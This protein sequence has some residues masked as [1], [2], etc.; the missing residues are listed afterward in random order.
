MFF[1]VFEKNIRSGCKDVF[2]MCSRKINLVITSTVNSQFVEC[3]RMSGLGFI[4]FLGFVPTLR[5]RISIPRIKFI[6]MDDCTDYI[7]N[8]F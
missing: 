3:D 5:N 1:S 2:N 7:R 6:C 8:S 4:V